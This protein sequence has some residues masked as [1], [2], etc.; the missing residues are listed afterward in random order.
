MGWIYDQGY[1]AKRLERLVRETTEYNAG[2]FLD[3]TPPLTNYSELNNQRKEGLIEK[4]LRRAR[5]K[6][7]IQQPWASRAIL[8]V[9]S[10]ML[11]IA[12]SPSKRDKEKIKARA[13]R[14]PCELAETSRD[15]AE[16]RRWGT[17]SRLV[18]PAQRGT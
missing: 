2:K 9:V 16:G 7:H 6:E 8:A 12:K 5:S 1:D 3:I 4:M 18:E 11:V 10:K 14:G 15:T 13:M 17:R